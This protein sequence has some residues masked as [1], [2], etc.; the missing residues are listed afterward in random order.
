MIILGV[1]PGTNIT[2]Y[3]IIRLEKNKISLITCGIIRLGN[4]DLDF[5]G[6]MKKI[7]DRSISII[8]DFKPEVLAIESP[9]VGKNIQSALKLGRAQGTVI[10]AALS[11]DL[12]IFEYMPKKVKKSVVGSGA[13]GKEQ[14]A[15]MLKHLIPELSNI[16]DTEDYFLDTT[17]ALAVAYCHA[18]QC[19]VSE[20]GRNNRKKYSN[21]ASFVT[22]NQ[23]RILK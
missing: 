23:N 3:G 17:D 5:P 4:T 12:P 7:F 1:D 2:G 10:A 15:G 20:D 14:I 9:F 19:T 11:Y 21:W 22:D 13:A 8:K 6:K 16:L 18:N